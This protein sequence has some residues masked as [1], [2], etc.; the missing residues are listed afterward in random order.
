MT[1]T[2]TAARPT[3]STINDDQLDRLHGQIDGLTALCKRQGEQLDVLQDER[4]DLRYN[5]AQRAF[6][7]P[8][9]DFDTILGSL[10]ARIAD[11]LARVQAYEQQPAH[12]AGDPDHC[13]ACRQLPASQVPD[14][15]CPGPKEQP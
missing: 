1:D 6:T 5:L 14:I 8:D 12:V 13:P 3:A 4:G 7:A 10:D 11:L 2:T 15:L 9:A